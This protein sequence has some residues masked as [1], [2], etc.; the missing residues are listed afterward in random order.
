MLLMPNQRIVIIDNANNIIYDTQVTNNEQKL[1]NAIRN[2]L[3]IQ[4]I[5]ERKVRL[6][7][8]DFLITFKSSSI[9]GWKLINIIPVSKLNSSIDKMMKNTLTLT[10]SLVFWQYSW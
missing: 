8:E 7:D 10:A 2:T 4:T 6:N 1:E 3:T 5:N 9:T